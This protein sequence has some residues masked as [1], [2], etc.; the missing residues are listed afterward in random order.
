MSPVIWLPLVANVV[1]AATGPWLA[2]RL[3]PRSAV[4]L[5]TF[6]MLATAAGSGLVLGVLGLLLVAQQPLVAAVGHWSPAVL[7][8]AQPVPT[9]IALAAGVIA[10]VLLAAALRRAVAGVRDLVGAAV[11]WRRLGPAGQGLVVLEAG[12]PDAYALPGGR[13]VVSRSMLDALQGEERRVLLAHEAAHLARGHHVF[14]Q[15]AELAAAASPILR[16]TATAVRLA[17]EREA[18][19]A[20]AT[21]V[22]DRR[23]AARALARAGLARAQAQRRGIAAMALP[24]ADSFVAIRAAALL[25]PAPR[26]RRALALALVL[27]TLATLSVST[28]T[29][30]QTD[31]RLDH[32]TTTADGSPPAYG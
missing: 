22:G 16:P 18:D 24:G 19:E 4:R 31:E 8:A 1:L 9:W 10:L 5:L 11:A 21:E 26:T 20:A 32:A 14:L 3:P 7:H 6:A 29:A 12:L 13:I 27:L 2:R 25:A 17:V 28:I 15:L 30:H 23:L